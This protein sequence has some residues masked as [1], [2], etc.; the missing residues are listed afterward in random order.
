MEF[1][2]T[3][4]GFCG[5]SLN[6]KNTCLK[7]SFLL[8]LAIKQLIIILIKENFHFYCSYE[9]KRSMSVLIFFVYP[10]FEKKLDFL[11]TLGRGFVFLEKVLR[12]K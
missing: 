12:A 1:H 7:C 8:I 5:K 10:K 3:L 4:S 9:S 2:S 11:N 6:G